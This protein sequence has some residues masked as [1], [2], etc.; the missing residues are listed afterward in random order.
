MS[1]LILKG[2]SVSRTRILT[3][4]IIAVAYLLISTYQILDYPTTFLTGNYEA[5]YTSPIP[6]E[7]NSTVQYESF[8]S[9]NSAVIY[10]VT[11]FS[12]NGYYQI[13]R[14]DYDLVIFN[15]TLEPKDGS[16]EATYRVG[17]SGEV[18]E[19]TELITSITTMKIQS[20]LSTAKASSDYWL[21]DVSVYVSPFDAFIYHSL[22]IWANSSISLCPVSINLKTTWGSNYF[23]NEHVH[24]MRYTTP[25]L[26]TSL[27]NRSDSTYHFYPRFANHTLYLRRGSLNGSCEWGMGHVYGIPFNVTFQKD[28]RAILTIHMEVVSV[29]VS[30]DSNYPVYLISFSAGSYEEVYYLHVRYGETP[31]ELYTPPMN[32][33]VEFY[34]VDPLN[35]NTWRLTPLAST[36]GYVDI[37]GS[38]NIQIDVYFQ[39]PVHILNW[40]DGLF[41]FLSLLLILFVVLRLGIWI[42]GLQEIPKH[43]LR[44]DF[45]FIPILLFFIFAFVPMYSSTKLHQMIFQ[46]SILTTHN[47]LLGPLPILAVWTEGSSVLLKIPSQAIMWSFLSLLFYW[48]PLLIFAAFCT[49]P[50]NRFNDIL[51]GFFLFIPAIFPFFLQTQLST[52]T[53]APVQ[54]TLIPILG[55]IIPI[56]WLIL[57]GILHV[58]GYYVFGNN[59]DS[60]ECDYLLTKELKS[61]YSKEIKIPQPNNV[62]IDVRLYIL[63]FI[64]FFIPCLMGFRY[65]YSNPTPDSIFQILPAQVLIYIYDTHGLYITFSLAALLV[66]VPYFGFSLLNLVWLWEYLYGQRTKV[67]VIFGCILSVASMIPGV[68]M[69]N[70]IG[71]MRRLSPYITWYTWAPLPIWTLIIFGLAFIKWLSK[72]SAKSNAS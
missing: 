52:V 24:D 66:G 4:S 55:L 63:V 64:M 32:L 62:L 23:D 1:K 28:Q 56:S 2:I 14:F 69:L 57:V 46:D 47:Q 9:S 43:T 44:F 51:M 10:N 6:Q 17:I 15:L 21:T 33:A 60:L 12:G 11:D 54:L 16:T 67:W 72:D 27:N 45:R 58:R 50:S 48:T 20:T 53:D 41:V 40:E 37:N 42:N 3:L 19:L 61:G 35:D 59:F 18:S 30:F 49:T 34:V 25:F 22:V 36:G 26:A 70:W 5:N 39:E 68:L 38:Y 65:S 13:P 29:E 31:I 71:Y 8:N 7:T